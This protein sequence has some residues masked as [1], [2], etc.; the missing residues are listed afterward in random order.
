MFQVKSLNVRGKLNILKDDESVPCHDQVIL[1]KENLVIIYKDLVIRVLQDAE[2]PHPLVG[3]RQI[4]DV[5]FNGAARRFSN[6]CREKA[7]LIQ[8]RNV[9]PF[10]SGSIL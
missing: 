2:G 7:T 10:R 8:S 3:Y 6:N 1:L 9:G 4:H 5:V